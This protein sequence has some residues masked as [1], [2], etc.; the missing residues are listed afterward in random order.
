MKAR[1]LWLVAPL[2]A[3]VC[4]W[5]LLDGS[6]SSMSAQAGSQ[7]ESEQR[8]DSLQQPDWAAKPTPSTS[9][10]ANSQATVAPPE[11]SVLLSMKAIEA[12]MPSVEIPKEWSPPAPSEP[13]PP[14]QLPALKP[15]GGARDQL[16]EAIRWFESLPAG[17]G[18][19]D[20]MEVARGK[21]A[22]A[23]LELITKE[24]RQ[25][26]CR[27]SFTYPKRDSSAPPRESVKIREASWSFTTI[28]SDGRAEGHIF[29]ITPD[30][31]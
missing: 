24:C 7:R 21:L 25:Q 2:V 31:R 23:R 8:A 18:S 6:V 3:G 4:V 16:I 15:G 26:I 13:A 28:A 29:V 1:W 30:R 22:R 5:A 19:P 20:E 27:L 12:R 9:H 14:P 17:N 11:D 10:V